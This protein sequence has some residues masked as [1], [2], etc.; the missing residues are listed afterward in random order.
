MSKACPSRTAAKSRSAAHEKKARDRL[1]SGPTHSWVGGPDVCVGGGFAPNPLGRLR[2]RKRICQPAA[3]KPL[4]RA[5]PTQSHTPRRSE[6]ATS[7]VVLAGACALAWAS[8]GP[9]R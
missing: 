9:L 7:L 1:K 6:V 3:P 8:A 4:R 5:G 2:I